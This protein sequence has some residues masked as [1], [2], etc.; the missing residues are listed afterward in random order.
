VVDVVVVILNVSGYVGGGVV[1]RTTRGGNIFV[2]G[3]GGCGFG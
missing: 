2:V 1:V 3:V